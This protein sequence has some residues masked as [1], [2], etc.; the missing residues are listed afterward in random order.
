[1]LLIYLTGTAI[2]YWFGYWNEEGCRLAASALRYPLVT[3][4]A[5]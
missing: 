1:M 3:I 5:T 2:G 4:D